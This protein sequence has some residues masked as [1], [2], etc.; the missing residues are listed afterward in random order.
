MDRA[1]DWTGALRIYTATMNESFPHFHCH[2]VPRYEKMPNDVVGGD[3]F[4]VLR[5]TGAG[6]VAVD[7]DEIGRVTAEYQAALANDPPPA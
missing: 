5:A 7:D 3:V 4:D 6:E 1:P 2:M